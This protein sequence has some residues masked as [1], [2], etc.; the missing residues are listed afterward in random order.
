MTLSAD[1]YFS[2]RSPYSYMA[3]GRYRKMA[4]EYDLDI[5]LRVVWP[6]AI[7]DPDIL[8][9]GNPA[10]PRYIMLDSFRTAQML[11][12]PFR[13][14]RPD[15]VVQN[16]T[17]REIAKEQPLIR[18]ICRLGQAASRRRKGLEFADEV[19]R[20]IFSGEV[21]DWHEGDHLADAAKRA[22]LDLAE[23]ED[24]TESDADALDAEIAANQDALE[25]AGH[26][27]VPTLV[28]EGEPFF[29]QD[30]IETAKWRM[31]HKG[32]AKR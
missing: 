22:G 1:L 32:L 3:I 23:L 10:A 20:I 2:F 12:L 25:A 15:P 27:G 8:F 7:R 4:E 26:W 16:L 24:E 5:N 11:G 21:D 18:R 6:I 19:S 31:E 9:T 29:G 13:W 14:P 17:T 30:R 28:F